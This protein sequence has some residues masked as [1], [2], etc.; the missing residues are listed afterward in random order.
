MRNVLL[1]AVALVA[2]YVVAAKAQIAGNQPSTTTV[3]VETKQHS[4]VAVIPLSA[5]GQPS[6]PA[7]LNVSG[8]VVLTQYTVSTLPTCNASL[9][10]SVVWVT[11]ATSPTYRGALTGSGTVGALVACDGTS[12][13]SQ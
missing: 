12:W 11:D 7:Q 2:L 10:A 3:T 6:G 13:T 9:K 1:A 8:A 4:I 5:L